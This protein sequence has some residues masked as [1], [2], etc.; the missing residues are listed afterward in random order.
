MSPGLAPA[1]LLSIYFNLTLYESIDQIDPQAYLTELQARITDHPLI[2][3]HLASNVSKTSG[4]A[5]NFTSHIQSDD[6]SWHEISH[7]VTIVAT[8]GQEYRGVDYRYGSHPRIP[9]QQTFETLLAD[10]A[11]LTQ[12][13]SKPPVD[14]ASANQV[15]MIQCIGPAEQFCARICCATALK[16]ALQLKKLHPSTQVIVLHRDIRTYGF[17]EHDSKE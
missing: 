6:G 8:G 3:L 10:E 9:T 13:T 15:V 12:A 2:T 7:G 4:F 14:L 17:K 5:G 16:N 11:G 1:N